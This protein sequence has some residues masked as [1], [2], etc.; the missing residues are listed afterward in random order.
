MAEYIKYLIRNKEPLRIADDSTSQSGQTTTLR[1]IP[2]TT[3][4]GWVIN[5]LSKRADFEQFKKELFS[6][7]VRYLNAYLNK[8]GKD[9]LPSPKGFYED[10]TVVEGKKKVENV[11]LQGDFP[12][13]YKRASLGR[14]AYMDEDC[15]H[16]F[17]IDTNSDMKIKINLE[18]G[19]DQNVFR[20]EY[21]EPGYCFSG[22]IAVENYEIGEMIRE[23]FSDELIL[24]NARSA[25]FGKCEILKCEITAQLPYEEY[26]PAEAQE[27]S[28]YMLLLSNTSLISETGEICGFSEEGLKYLEEK[29][30]VTNLDIA[31][32][33]TSTINVRGYNRNWGI[34]IPSL[35][36]YEQGSVFHLIYNGTLSPEKMRELADKGI[37]IRRN[38]GFG[39]VVFLKDYEQI[40]YKLG[41]KYFDSAREELSAELTEEDRKVLKIAARSYYRNKLQRSMQEYVIKEA[42]QDRTFWGSRTSNSQ[43]GELDARITANKYNPEEAKRVIYKYLNHANEKEEANSVQKAH[44]SLKETKEFVDKLYE[45]SLA[46]LVGFRG[47]QQGFIMGI[48][49]AELLSQTEEETLKL[50]LLISLI[51]F[52]NK[53]DK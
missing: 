32:C 41:E 20:N 2:G 52:K 50:E 48:P 14:F 10:K 38:E 6:D 16:Y 42:T 34:K 24:G 5:K 18:K 4:R 23:L 12:E 40:Q 26:L 35:T 15:V 7:K 44:N 29:M 17:N 28:C 3:I 25:G 49:T 33:S 8:D 11:V 53:G 21:M 30:G 39:R 47:K 46:E 36:A 31:F 45:V 22:Y 37:G 51:R 9:L 43:L 1:Y 27:N 13:G 19:E